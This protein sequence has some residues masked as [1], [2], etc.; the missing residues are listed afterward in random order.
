[1]W[2]AQVLGSLCVCA[3]MCM[4]TCVCVCVP[5]YVGGSESL[6]HK[7]HR[8][9]GQNLPLC[10]I[11]V[12]VMQL[13]GVFVLPG[14]QIYRTGLPHSVCSFMGGGATWWN[15]PSPAP[16][17]TRVFSQFTGA[18]TRSWRSWLLVLLWLAS[19]SAQSACDYWRLFTLSQPLWIAD[20]ALSFNVDLWVFLI[21]SLLADCFPWQ[22]HHTKGFVFKNHKNQCN[23]E[24]WWQHA[25]YNEITHDRVQFQLFY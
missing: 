14:S 19:R 18:Q 1:M 25:C 13:C 4:W 2:T 8:S 3:C 21:L 9:T 20:Q 12:Y 24:I 22:P 10:M 15:T 6:W 23:L 11:E 17:S 5:V 7:D 16:S